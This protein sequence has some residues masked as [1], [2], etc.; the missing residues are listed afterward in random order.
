MAGDACTETRTIAPGA[1]ST[2]AFIAFANGDSSTC[3]AGAKFIGSGQVTA[4]STNQPLVGIVN[5][6]LPGVNGEA[7]NAFAP[8]DGSSTLVMPLIMDRNNG[9]F[10]GFAVANIGNSTTTVNCTFSATD[11]VPNPTYKVN[12]NLA[13]GESVADLQ[14]NKIGRGLYR[15]RNLHCQRW[16][17][18][19]RYRQ[20]AMPERRP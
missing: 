8:T 6:L 20:P 5:Q 9:Y 14:Q 2:F 16:R 19:R 11:K 10:T 12:A 15:L 1:S 13:P 3:T 17:L 18:H 4:N 7:Y